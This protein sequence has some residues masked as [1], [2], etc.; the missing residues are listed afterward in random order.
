MKNVRLLLLW[1]TTLFLGVPFHL[2]AQNNSDYYEAFVELDGNLTEYQSYLLRQAGAEITARYQGFIT[3][4]AS[5]DINPLSFLNIDGV[6]HVTQAVTL[7]TCSDS[8]RYY[9][10]VEP[11]H[12]GT[13]FEMPYT[14]EGVIVGVIDCGFDFNHINLCDANGAP[15]VKAVYMPLDNSGNQP[16]V[17][18]VKLPGSC[19]ES[20]A[21]IV[22]LTTDDPNTTHGTQTAGIA[23]GA[24]RANGWYG[25]A[26]GADIVACGMPE[27]ELNDVRVA[28]CISYIC[29]YAKRKNKPCVINISLGS[30]VGPHDGT[31]YLNRVCSQLSGPGRVFVASAGNDGGYAVT[32]HRQTSGSTDTVTTLLDGYRGSVH[33]SG[34]VNAWSNVKKPF[35]TR[36]VVVNVNNG[37][38]VYRGR[39]LGAT[40]SGVMATFSSENDET[41]AQYFTGSVDIMGSIEA[42]GKPNSIAKIE[43]VANAGNYVLGFQYYG[44]STNELVISTSKYAYF[45]NYGYSWAEKGTSVG[46]ISDIA[47][48]DSVISVG[49]YN[50][51]QYVPLRDGTIYYRMNSV[52]EELSF[53]SSYGPDESGNNRPDVCAP[54]SVLISSANRY[55]TDAPNLQYWQTPAIVGGVEYPYCPDLGTSMSAPVVSGAVALWLQ[56]N[57][58]LAVADVR[59]ILYH[60]SY[61]DAQVL[62]DTRGRW[63]S[64]KLDVNA[65]LRY[66]LHIE[67]K[68]GDVNGDG[69]VNI[70]DINSAIHIIL[71]GAADSDTMRRA[72][73]NND[74]EVNISD[75]NMIIGVI[76]AH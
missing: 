39:A 69:E 26:P 36:L 22:Q 32:I 63:G 41:L 19:Y 71:G 75:I 16:V 35:N 50:S 46:S 14:G 73:V 29:D 12:L 66:V 23:A 53:F 2:C 72:D 42:N 68:N 56:A 48:C 54:G 57:P 59:D 20:A 10:R 9:S 74:G 64:G 58:N 30:N 7:L 44:P 1:L 17:N 11:V 27:G 24:Y 15:R 60:S 67:D 6:E 21:Q 70:S 5:Q 45:R 33:Y 8:A 25:I 43:M 28:H 51:K 37:A 40:S 49:S 61:K 76:L 31:S 34:Y 38:I 55:D 4:R 18:A 3:I 65:G 13:G 47:S 52:P 62:S